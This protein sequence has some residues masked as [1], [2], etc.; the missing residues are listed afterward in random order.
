MT[1]TTRPCRPPAWRRSSAAST[2]RSAAGPASST[3]RS[4]RGSIYGA[5]STSFNPSYDGSFGLTLAA[6]GVNNAALPPERS[7]NVEVG[8]KWDVTSKLFAT[9]AVFHTEKTNAKTTDATTGATVLA[10]D[11][12]VTGVEFG[13]SGNLTARWGIFTGLSLM[14]GT[15]KESLVAAEV[16]QRLSYVPEQSFNLWSTYRL[17]RSVTVGARRAV[18]RRLLLQQHQRADHGQRGGDS[19]ADAVLAV[20]RDGEPSGQPAPRA[21][22]EPEQPGERALRGTRLHRPLRARSRPLDPRESGH[23]VLRIRNQ[24]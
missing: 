3:S 22:G 11:Q 19:A 5:F 17:P 12:Q 16:D 18:H 10:G 13:L 6:T 21:A 14:D 20:Q 23:H 4:T 24:K 15:I 2:R 9:V 8:T 1:W 7:R